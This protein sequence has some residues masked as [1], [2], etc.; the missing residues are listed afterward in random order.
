[1][2]SIGTGVDPTGPELHTRARPPVKL[3]AGTCAVNVAEL[4][5][6]VTVYPV[7]EGRAAICSSI[8]RDRSTRGAAWPTSPK[9]VFPPHRYRPSSPG[10]RLRLRDNRPSHA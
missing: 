7:A 3:S 1:M 10:R 4:A 5:L 8:S 9:K 2:G 6:K